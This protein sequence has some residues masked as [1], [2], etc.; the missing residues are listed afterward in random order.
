M[1]LANISRVQLNPEEERAF[2]LQLVQ[3]FSDSIFMDL[4]LLSLANSFYLEG[5]N[6]EALRYYTEILNKFPRSIYLTEVRDK[7]RKIRAGLKM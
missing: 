1:R 2:L 3:K 5:N 6:D 7:I 4:A